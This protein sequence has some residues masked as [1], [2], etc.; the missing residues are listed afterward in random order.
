MAAIPLETISGAE[1]MVSL[2]AG[3]IPASLAS[4]KAPAGTTRW[5]ERGAPNSSA[6]VGCGRGAAA[7]AS[8]NIKGRLWAAEVENTAEDIK[9]S[10]RFQ[11]TPERESGGYFAFYSPL[12]IVLLGLGIVK[13]YANMGISR[14]E[15]DIEL[16]STDS[17]GRL[18][19][20]EHA[21]F[22]CS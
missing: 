14:H 3:V 9:S 10:G 8:S 19:P 15:A 2:E 12:G 1:R 13:S 4:L 18:S 21:T 5:G 20:H 22:R 16:R 11:G 7:V 17:R 6:P